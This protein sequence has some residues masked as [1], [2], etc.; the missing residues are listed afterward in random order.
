M[1]FFF[2]FNWGRKSCMLLQVTM[3]Q[4]LVTYLFICTA[5]CTEPPLPFTHPCSA[6]LVWFILQIFEGPLC[7]RHRAKYQGKILGSRNKPGPW[8]HGVYGVVGKTDYK[9]KILIIV[10]LWRTTWGHGNILERVDPIWEAKEGSQRSDD[11]AELKKGQGN[12][13]V[14][15]VTWPLPPPEAATLPFSLDLFDLLGGS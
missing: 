11:W 2:S 1:L 8:L 5:S 7:S 6:A 9:G 10:R 13:W 14:R 3:S 12:R 15:W 4:D